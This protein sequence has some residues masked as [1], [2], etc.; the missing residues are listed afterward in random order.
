MLNFIF[1][2]PVK[3][4][5][6]KS[7]LTNL[8]KEI[9]PQARVLITYG[10]GSIKRNGVY[11]QVKKELTNYKIFEFGGIEPNPSYETLMQAVELARKEK[12]DFLLA[13][14]G[15]SVADGTKFIAAAINFPG[16]P[17]DILANTS[18]SEGMQAIPNTLPFGVVLTLPATGSEMNAG[19]V[20]SK[21]ATKDK[22]AFMNANGFPKFSILDPTITFSLPLDQ[23]ANGIVDAFIHVT[24]QYLTYPVNS[25]VQDRFAEGVLLTLIAEAP[26]VMQKADDYDA[27]ANIMFSATMGLNGILSMG[28][29]EDWAT[30]LIGHELTALFGIAHGPSLAIVLPS[31]LASQRKT[32]KEKLLQ[33]ASRVWGIDH[34]DEDLCID[35]AIRQ[36]KSFFESLGIKTSLTDYGVTKNDIA[37]VIN[38]LKGHQL[39]ALGERGLITLDVVQKILEDS[40]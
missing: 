18:F 4:I 30:H 14:G 32:K 9:P 5:F 39:T 15:G 11:E 37:T 3:L 6:G 26:K 28:V 21:K 12:I 35:D 13:V 17:W 19:A 20:I 38:K 34:G 40:L 25:P 8:A 16:D 24:E 27:R 23:T 29:P 36:T 10:G 31:L 33:Y 1:H 7:T 22:L 2:N